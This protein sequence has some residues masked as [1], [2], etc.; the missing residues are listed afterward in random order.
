MEFEDAEFERYCLERFDEDGDGMIIGREVRNIREMN[1]SELGITS[2]SGIEAFENLESLYYQ[3][4]EL[5]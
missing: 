1:V 5:S 2:L 4:K 3:G